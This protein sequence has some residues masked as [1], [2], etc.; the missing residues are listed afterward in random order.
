LS[1]KEIFDEASNIEAQIAFLS[2]QMTDFKKRITQLV[3]ENNRLHIENEHLK[4]ILKDAQA[5]ENQSSDTNEIVT[6]PNK[7]MSNLEKIYRDGFHICH[8]E[9]GSPRVEEEN[10]LF[11]MSLINRT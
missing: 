8:F 3:E 9:F 7:A 1:K 6:R 4:T 11:C 10:C 5:E 2:E